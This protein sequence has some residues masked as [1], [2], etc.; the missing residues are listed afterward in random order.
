VSANFLQRYASLIGV[1]VA[2]L[3]SHIFVPGDWPWWLRL[4]V[5]MAVAL[6]IYRFLYLE[7][8]TDRRPEPNN[9]FRKRGWLRRLGL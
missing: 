4:G 5:F 8:V 9:P 7:G 6:S 2:A 1:L 3:L